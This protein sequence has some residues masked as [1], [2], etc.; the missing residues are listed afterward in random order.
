MQSVLARAQVQEQMQVQVAG[1][2]A[3][4]EGAASYGPGATSQGTTDA[5]GSI[6]EKN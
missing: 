5:T 3:Q 1:A 4:A 6:I 2:G